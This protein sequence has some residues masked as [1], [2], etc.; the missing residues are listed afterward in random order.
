MKRKKI[1]IVGLG[2]I[3]QKA[4][5]PILG[6]HP[7][8]QIEGILSRRRETVEAI[9]ERYRIQGRF[10][11]LEALLARDLD[12]VFVHSPTETH[13]AI[14]TA[15]LE[16]GIAVYV[17]KPLAYELEACE[18]MAEAARAQGTLLAAGFNRRFAPMYA[19]AKAWLE[20][21][22][23][24]DLCAAQKH[25]TRPQA[26]SARETMYDDLI[27]VVD[28][29]LWLGAGPHELL[30]CLQERDGDGR[31]LHVSGSLALGRGFSSEADGRRGSG[32]AM[33]WFSMNRR[34]GADLEKLELHGG[35][36]SVEVTNLES[37]VW[38]DARTGESKRQFGSWETIGVRRG[39]AGAVEHFLETLDTPEKCTIRADRVLETHRLIER[40]CREGEK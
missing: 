39:F 15:C 40:L 25:R 18:R 28:L 17:D 8:V 13:E 3:A 19:E 37:A 35:G 22:G 2:D 27:H 29:L 1:A 36:R 10:L 38:R 23:G 4:Y 26:L 32:G 31:L 30:G 20:E 9:G 11:E 7:G 33:A 14:V 21:A 12:A 16:R 34:A 24:F 6:Q 5:L